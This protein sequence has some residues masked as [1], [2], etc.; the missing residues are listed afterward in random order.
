MG[1]SWGGMSRV[2]VQIRYNWH[3]SAELLL[4]VRVAVDLAFFI[5]T[6]IVKQFTDL[7]AGA[8]NF[9]HRFVKN[10]T[11]VVI[12]GQ[13]LFLDSFTW[14]FQFMMTLSA[15]IDMAVVANLLV[16]SLFAIFSL[17]I[18]AKVIAVKASADYAT[19]SC[20]VE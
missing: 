6:T 16:A 1:P 11:I 12:A 13:S 14:D 15:T 10:F 18:T 19:I 4:P 20:F 9:Y 3:L 7:V 17:I 5:K 8:L 2:D